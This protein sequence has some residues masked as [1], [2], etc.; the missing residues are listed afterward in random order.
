MLKYL[1]WRWYAVSP[2]PT[3]NTDA[4]IR[5]LYIQAI[6]YFAVAPIFM[7]IIKETRHSVILRRIAKSKG[8]HTP[9][10]HTAADWKSWA[11]WQAAIIRP[12]Q[13]LLTEPAVFFPTMWSAFS[14]GTIFLFTQ[15]IGQVYSQLY[16]W[17]E[18]SQGLVLSAIAVG[19]VL[20]CLV[21]LFQDDLYFKSAK[22]NTECPGTPIPEARL[23]LT[24]PGTI[25]V[26]AGF[27]IYAW[28]S[29]S[30]M[31]WIA[32]TIGLG[33]VGFGSYTIVLAVAY[34]LTDAYPKYGA[35]SFAAGVLGENAVASFLPF[36][37]RQMYTTLG[38]QW[39]SSLLGFVALV[40][41]VIP[42]VFLI[43]GRTIRERSR[44]IASAGY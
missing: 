7:I 31:P 44:F 8:I 33:C 16:G 4:S 42:I 27:F 11:T 3:A 35:S 43:Y 28:T 21:Q 24:I 23:Y 10:D 22:R 37:T 2:C 26:A 39:A 25:I 20:G 12:V 36:S 29:Y 15:S 41:T 18:S 19:Q 17:S 30:S 34:W 9:A 32:P 13:M 6:I 38:L 5:I 1:D 40:M 14:L